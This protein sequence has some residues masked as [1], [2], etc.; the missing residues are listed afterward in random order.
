MPPVVREQRIS[1]E[2]L[3]MI[4]TTRSLT[5]CNFDW[6]KCASNP[7]DASC[8]K[9]LKQRAEVRGTQS[10]SPGR[11]APRRRC[12]DSSGALSIILVAGC[13]QMFQE[14]PATV[15]GFTIWTAERSSSNAGASDELK[16]PGDVVA[17]RARPRARRLCRPVMVECGHWRDA[18]TTRRGVCPSGQRRRA[19]NPLAL[20]L[21]RF[22][23]YR[24][25]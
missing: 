10:G 14:A 22:E 4:N 3:L 25:H 1:T 5:E 2:S 9:R 13:A 15:R 21:R 7:I 8:D 6:T 17:S 11:D 19:V 12:A 23:S 18:C 24:A 16:I 20:R